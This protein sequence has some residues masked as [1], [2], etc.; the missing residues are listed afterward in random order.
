M[1]LH[2]DMQVMKSTTAT[3][4]R[5][6]AVESS[7]CLSDDMTDDETSMLPSGTVSSKKQKRGSK[8]PPS[9]APETIGSR[10]GETSAKNRREK[11]FEVYGQAVVLRVTSA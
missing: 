4:S 11:C 6:L 7:H 10:C 1:K 8:E 3:E 5:E 9:T 2:R